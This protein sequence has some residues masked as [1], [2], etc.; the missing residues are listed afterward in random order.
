MKVELTIKPE[1]YLLCSSNNTGGIIDAQVILDENGL[2]YF[3]GK[4]FKGL[5]KES[6][7]EV[8]EFRGV[9]NKSEIINTLFGEEGTFTNAGILSFTNFYTTKKSISSS[10]EIFQTINKTSIDENEIAK[11]GSLRTFKV[12]DPTSGIEF[13][14]EII[15]NLKDPELN[16]FKEAVL[17]LRRAG[18]GRNRGDG[19]IKVSFVEIEALPEN[20]IKLENQKVSIIDV[21]IKTSDPLIL[22]K[23]GS[24]RNTTFSND[25]IS[26][27]QLMGSIA[28]QFQNYE[29]DLFTNLFLKNGLQFSFCYPEDS[30]PIPSCLHS[31]KYLPENEKKIVNVLG[32]EDTPITKKETG[33]MNSHGKIKIGKMINFHNSRPNR[34]KGKSDENEGSI[35]YYEAINK[36]T[37]FSGKIRGESEKLSSLLNEFGSQKKVLIGKSKSSQYGGANLKLTQKNSDEI[38]NINGI[39]YFYLKTPLIIFNEFGFPSSNLKDLSNELGINFNTIIGSSIQVDYVEMYN[40]AWNSKSGRFLCFKEGSCI[41]IDLKKNLPKTGF[42][43]RFI[44]K[45]FGEYLL[46]SEEEMESF[47]KILMVHTPEDEASISEVDS[48]EMKG[49]EKSMDSAYNNLSNSLIG[50]LIGL[51]NVSKNKEEFL[52]EVNKLK[53]KKAGEEISAVFLYEDFENTEIANSDFILYWKSFFNALRKKIK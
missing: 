26:G 27:S 16:Y 44:E 30:F 31:V 25:H 43:G 38:K 24:N 47:A 18:L 45:G 5:L 53:G 23:F 29:S 22:S 33:L 8:L 37:K 52:D 19:K 1:S 46:Y 50:R 3:P 7:I 21:E 15:L 36:G 12:L 42:L 48:I 34:L 41:K 13:K 28:F 4:T 32:D 14:S 35:F 20:N 6:F 2:P 51:L 9:K 49:I 17:N 39:V 11:E 10:S 40:S